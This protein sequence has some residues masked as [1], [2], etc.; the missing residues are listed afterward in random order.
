VKA[1]FDFPPVLCSGE[2]SAPFHLGTPV[3]L[4]LPGLTAIETLAPTPPDPGLGYWTW[5]AAPT[6]P[7][8]AAV[9]IDCGP[10]DDPGTPVCEVVGQGGGG[11]NYP[12]L[13][14]T[15]TANGTSYTRE[16]S[17]TQYRP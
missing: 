8:Y 14:V 9:T 12:D 3:R 6:A 15:I 1:C 5:S 4:D 2:W 11:G 7:P 10:D 17:W 16:Y 13:V